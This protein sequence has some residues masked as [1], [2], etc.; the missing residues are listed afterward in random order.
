MIK[1]YKAFTADTREDAFGLIRGRFGESACGVAEKVLQNPA[2]K[3]GVSCGCIGYKDDRPVCMQAEML[4]TMYVGMRKINGLVGGLT[5]KVKKGCPLSILLETINHAADVGQDYLIAFGNSCCGETARLNEA[6]GDTLGPKT[7]TRYL[8]RAIRPVECGMYFIRRKLLKWDAPQWKEF[9]TLSSLGFEKEYAG[10]IIRRLIDVKPVFFDALMSEYVKTN[11]G[12]VC[13]RTAEEIEWIFGE[14][15]R[16]GQCVLLAAFKAGK[17]VGYIII[18][19]SRTAKRCLIYDWFAL[20]NN[21]NTLE[22]LLCTGCTYLKKYTPAM[23]LEVC[24]F[25]TWIQPLL[26]RYLPHERPV[27]N[28]VF[29]W[30]SRDKTFRDNVLLPLI[31]SPKSWFFGPYDGDLCMCV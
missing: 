27:G 17:P 14:H 23:M 1:S 10:L 31:D 13:S 26:K 21:E 6:S 15:I 19:V 8:W 9:S 30:D 4:R 11:E 22:A 18:K 7:C 29:A 3:G 16:N 25:P 20:K 2:H 24:G 28:N 12:V 5:C